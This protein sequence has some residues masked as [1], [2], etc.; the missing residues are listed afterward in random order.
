MNPYHAA[1][2]PQCNAET[3]RRGH[4]SI[5]SP[6]VGTGAIYAVVAQRHSGRWIVNT[7]CSNARTTTLSPPSLDRNDVLRFKP[8]KA[9][10]VWRRCESMAVLF[11]EGDPPHKGFV[12]FVCQSVHS[13]HLQ[14]PS[15][16]LR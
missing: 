11:G 14:D 8:A 12:V 15:E 7:F 16:V 3:Q 4:R 1:A 5:Q 2:S 10:T 6:V 9:A 13:Y